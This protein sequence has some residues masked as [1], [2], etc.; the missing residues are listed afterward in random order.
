M[1]KKSDTGKYVV[2]VALPFL[3]TSFL[4]VLPA[5]AA[6][7]TLVP[8]PDVVLL[9]G[10]PL[11]IA[12]DGSGAEGQ[13]LTFGA[14][15]NNEVVN[16]FIT[17]GNRSLRFAVTGFG[18]M[19]YE[20]FEA[21]VPRVTERIIGLSESG[22]Y[23]GVIF[24]RVINDFVIQGGDPTGTGMGLP[25][26]PKFDDQFHMDLQH[27]RSGLLSMAK[28]GDDTNSSQFFVTEG[29]QRHLDFNHSIFG[30]LIEGE[31]VRD[32][33]SNVAVGTGDRPIVDVV[34]ETVEVF[35]DPHNA[36]LML[37]AP[38]GTTGT[39]MVTVTVTNPSGEQTEQT[40]RVDVN[41]DTVN[42]PP[43][44]ADI[45]L[46]RTK[47]D[48]PITVQL[49]AI[50]VEGDVAIYLDETNLDRNGLNVPLRAPADLSYS[51]G[52]ETGVLTVTPT[53]GL[54]GDFHITVA[55]A[56]TRSA[57]DYQVVPVIIEP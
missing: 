56:A 45:P 9:S 25:D 40:F 15:S 38:E 27:N 2:S 36:V 31:D 19:V 29:A 37:K 22:F 4:M 13:P 34:M 51:V 32:A 17:Q 24:H 33:I 8:I 55:T 35:V 6:P 41:P 46:I 21:R 20:L 30:L 39:S 53:N 5:S 10:S 28:A 18:V 1:H 50:D 44:L 7:P 12:L 23:N 54:T 16:T 43:F 14:T 49:Q 47:V 52:S 57:V 42:S 26:L 3:C 48:T 11:H